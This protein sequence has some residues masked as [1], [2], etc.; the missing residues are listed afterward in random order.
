M[1]QKLEVQIETWVTSF[2]LL[3]WVQSPRISHLMIRKIVLSKLVTG[4]VF[5]S[6]RAM[7]S[8]THCAMHGLWLANSNHWLSPSDV[9]VTK[10]RN[11]R[12]LIVTLLVV[13]IYEIV[14]AHGL[15]CHNIVQ[16]I[17]T[18][19]SLLKLRRWLN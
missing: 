4:K 7:D 11:V 17:R 10:I 5:W 2:T 14:L 8:L 3:I 19:C 18:R 1:G 9:V 15:F 16:H 13:S 12:E 6:D